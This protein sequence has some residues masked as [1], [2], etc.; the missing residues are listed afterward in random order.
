MRPLDLNYSVIELK[1]CDLGDTKTATAGKTHNDSV[2]SVV[3]RS[4]GAGDQ[5]GQDGCK[6]ATAQ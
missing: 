6:L 3:S 2:P 1:A 5:V 4:V